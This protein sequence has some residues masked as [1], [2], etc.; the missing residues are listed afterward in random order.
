MRAL[1]TLLMASVAATLATSAF[2]Q[3]V[4]VLRIGLDGSENE[5]DQIRRTECIVEPLKAATGVSE[6]QLFPSPD[7]NGIIQGLMGGTIDIAQMG[8]SSY[9]AIYLQNPDAVDPILTTVGSDGGTGYYSL[10]VARKDSGIKTLADLKGKKLGFADPD[11][12]SGYLV[13][14]VALPA[15]IGMPVEEFFGET[16]FGGGHENLVLGVLDGTWDAG[17]TFGSGVGDFATGYTSG[18]LFT[19]VQKGLLDTDDIVELWRSPL[20]PNGP[21]M[22]SMKLPED[23]RTKI[24]AFFT[25]LPKTDFACF[26]SFTAGENTDFAQVDE[27]FY[28]TIIDARRSVIGD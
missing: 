26:Q 19:M 13:P 9:A 4:S 18:N 27:S 21:L 10:M 3:D 28:Q 20:I 25:A 6:V 2:A 1:R 16:G 22:V 15:E 17:T 12:T 7:Y 8:A 14:N 11:S 24:E 5:A 23:M